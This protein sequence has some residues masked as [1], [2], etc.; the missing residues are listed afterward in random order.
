MKHVTSYQSRSGKTVEC[1][2]GKAQTFR[3]AVAQIPGDFVVY[4]DFEI[5]SGEWCVEII[6]TF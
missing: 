5:R 3:D 6:R 4:W 1:W 2:R